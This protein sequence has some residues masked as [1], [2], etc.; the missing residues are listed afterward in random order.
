MKTLKIKLFDPLLIF[1]RKISSDVSFFSFPRKI[2]FISESILFGII[3]FSTMGF[4]DREFYNYIN[5]IIYFVAAVLA[6]VYVLL[7]GRFKF[8]S[9]FFLL[10]FFNIAGIISYLINGSSSFLSTPITV[11]IVSLILYEFLSQS[12][13]E[14]EMSLFFALVGSLAFILYFIIEYHSSIFNPVFDKRIGDFFGNEN[15]VARFFAFSLL[16]NYF[17]AFSKKFYLC[18]ISSAAAFYCILL[19]GSISNLITISLV[20]FVATIYQL[21]KKNRIILLTISILLLFLLVIILQIPV[22]SYYKTRIEAIITGLA[23]NTNNG[24]PSAETRLK[25]AIE[26][27]Y[28]FLK[29]PLYGYGYNGVINNSFNLQFA[30][31]NI[32]EVAA[33]FGLMGLI[34]F[35]ILVFLPLF[36]IHKIKSHFN[37]FIVLICLYIGIFQIFLVSYYSKMEYVTLAFVYAHLSNFEIEGI[38]TYYFPRFKVVQ[39]NKFT[40]QQ[41]FNI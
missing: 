27:F 21:N 10:L 14:K 25:L 24:D 22:F 17:F 1:F 2:L 19:T 4:S 12:S 6:T 40:C 41:T 35:E 7:Y 26:A 18:Y 28:L 9:F 38:K 5:I 20:I 30:H 32:A 13:T 37:F 11:A 36:K 15:D 3:V 33:D 29:K 39:K 34:P 16:I 31:N 23:G 8:C